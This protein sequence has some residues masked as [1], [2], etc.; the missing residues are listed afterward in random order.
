M[1]SE[2]SVLIQNEG[3][4]VAQEIQTSLARFLEQSLQSYEA[5]KVPFGRMEPF[6]EKVESWRN[7]VERFELFCEANDVPAEK[8]AIV[9]FTV[10]GSKWYNTFRDVCVPEKPRSQTFEKT[11]EIIGQ[12]LEP[13][14]PNVNTE[15]LKFGNCHQGNGDLKDFI[16]RLKSLAIKCDYA[17]EL[18]TRL[19][20]Q[21]LLGLNS[22]RIRK[23]LLIERTLNWEKAIKIAASMD[24]ERIT[25]DSIAKMQHV[26]N[27]QAES[28][29]SS[30]S[31]NENEQRE[32]RRSGRVVKRPE[33]DS[34]TYDLPSKKQKNSTDWRDEEESETEIHNLK[35]EN[36][37]LKMELEETNRMQKELTVLNRDLQSRLVND[38]EELRTTLA[39]VCSSDINQSAKGIL[40]VG[41]VRRM[42]KHVHLGR[43]V[44]IP[45]STFDTVMCTA[46]NPSIF[47]KNMA[48]A[49][50]GHETLERSSVTGQLSNRTKKF[51]EGPPKQKLD[52]TKLLAIKDV[53][54]Y[55][56]QDIKKVDECTMDIELRK[57]GSYIGHKIADLNR[58]KKDPEETQRTSDDYTRS[59]DDFQRI[60]LYQRSQEN[61]QS[62]YQRGSQNA[63]R[64]SMDYERNPE[65]FDMMMVN[66]KSETHEGNDDAMHGSGEAVFIPEEKVSVQNGIAV[67]DVSDEVH[68]VDDETFIPY[69]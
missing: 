65:T 25:E 68:N 42:D 41:Y 24:D 4:Q 9:F 61:Y 44:W 32:C 55:W 20:D 8:K 33:S 56:L 45:K 47:I 10:M 21:F 19:L 57:V 2:G 36:N 63:Q 67:E 58:R 17:E 37:R 5:K 26:V 59:S 46:R 11:V 49:V 53:F 35:L 16:E 22:E 50:F 43:E 38:Y 14:P 54:R 18:K 31:R 60:D 66:V 52:P 48:L 29:I 6:D 39:N 12:Y 34:Y 3:L 15:R 7:Y 51:Y 30:G 62:H 13:K 40:P 23:R 64:A 27:L 69:L 1:E 28:D